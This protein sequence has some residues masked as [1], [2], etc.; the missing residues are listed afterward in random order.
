[1]KL[2]MVMLEYSF[3]QILNGPTRVTQTTETQ[4]D[5]LF[6]TNPDLIAYSR[7]RELGLSDHNMIYGMLG[8]GVGRKQQ[9]WCEIRALVNCD[10]EKLVEEL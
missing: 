9:C 2:G 8:E 5:L 3:E 4:I 6:T 7:C 1:M 10:V